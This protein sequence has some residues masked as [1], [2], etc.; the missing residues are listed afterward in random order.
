[1]KKCYCNLCG[2]E[3]NF[4]DIQEEF[5]IKSSSIGYGSKH[6]GDALELDL[7]CDCMD[8]LIDRCKINPI[9]SLSF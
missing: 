8:E 6:D 5:S 2:K 3:M 7:C 9:T 1:M 4:W